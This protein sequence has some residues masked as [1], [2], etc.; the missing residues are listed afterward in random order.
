M[1]GIKKP[2]CDWVW[3][4]PECYCQN[5]NTYLRRLR[6]CNSIIDKLKDRGLK[7]SI[8]LLEQITNLLYMKEDHRIFED[9]AR[10]S[11]DLE[12]DM[13]LFD[14]RTVY[15]IINEERI[16]KIYSSLKDNE[17]AQPEIMKGK[18]C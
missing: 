14:D 18:Y 15:N 2:A 13:Y 11:E 10:P 5:E 12:F 8:K 1:M 17:I 7:L 9:L 16:Y 3:D 6:L 4:Y